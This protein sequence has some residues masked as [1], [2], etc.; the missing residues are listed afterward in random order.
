MKNRLSRILVVSILAFL[1]PVLVIAGDWPQ[2]RGPDRDGVSSETGLVA[3][4]ARV[5]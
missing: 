2:Y 5:R 3:D 4:W 1:L